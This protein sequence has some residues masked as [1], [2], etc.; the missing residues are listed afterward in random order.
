MVVV[1]I[2]EIDVMQN[3]I[4]RRGENV[5]VGIRLAGNASVFFSTGG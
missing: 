4:S 2:C 1:E 5:V 3:E